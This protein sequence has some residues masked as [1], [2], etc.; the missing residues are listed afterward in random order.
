M[1]QLSSQARAPIPFTSLPLPLTPLIGREQEVLSLKSMLG[2]Y[3]RRLVTLTGTGGVGKTHL[4]LAVAKE[5]G[6]VFADGVL[7]LSL[8]ALLRSDLVLVTLASALG[9]SVREQHSLPA[10]LPEVP[11]P[12]AVSPLATVAHP[13]VP[14]WQDA[15]TAREGE[16]L[17]LLAEGKTNRQIGE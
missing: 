4:A 17:R 10:S 3:E 16:V 2:Q 8:E 7:F 6:P 14:G 12:R 5:L 13:V 1:N 9:I 11:L 15:L